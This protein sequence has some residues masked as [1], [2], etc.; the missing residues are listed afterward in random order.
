[1]PLFG[2]EIEFA[3]Q[4]QSVEPTCSMDSLDETRERFIKHLYGKLGDYPHLPSADLPHGRF[5][6]WGGQLCRERGHRIEVATPEVQDLRSAVIYERTIERMLERVVKSVTDERPYERCALIKNNRDYG[7]TRGETTQGMHRSVLMHRRT[8]LGFLRQQLVP[9]LITRVY[10]GAGTLSHDPTCS[11]IAVFQRSAH[12]RKECGAPYELSLVSQRDESLCGQAYPFYRRQHLEMDDSLMSELGMYLS[13]ITVMVMH[14]IDLGVSFVDDICITNS[15]QLFRSISDHPSS[16]VQIDRYHRLTPCEVQRR[17]F[18]VLEKYQHALPS[19][20]NEALERLDH[21]LSL[22]ESGDPHDRLSLM[23]DFFIKRRL[24]SD[25]LSNHGRRWGEINLWWSAIHASRIPVFILRNMSEGFLRHLYP[26]TFAIHQ[27]TFNESPDLHGIINNIIDLIRLD[28]GYHTLGDDGL[29]R[30]LD[31]A[32][33]LRHRLISDEEI[34]AALRHPPETG[35]RSDIRG[36]AILDM[37]AAGTTASASWTS[38]VVSES[39]DYLDLSDPWEQSERWVR[40]IVRRFEDLPPFLQRLI[41][42]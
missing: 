5:F 20:A 6:S 36:K 26:D 28:I 38:V 24:F 13:A 15:T 22:I 40:R 4:C 16:H 23:L 10:S 37:H 8:S 19:Y 42:Y 9:F 11:S 25:Y 2:S 27:A 35:T 39:Q 1:M 31:N 29:F 3:I 33:L 17:Y 41:N 32:G 7:Y 18:A 34:N 14:L 30:R 12:I 21:V